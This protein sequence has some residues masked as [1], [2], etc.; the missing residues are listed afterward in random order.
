MFGFLFRT[1]VFQL[2]IQSDWMTIFVLSSLFVLSIF[3]IWIVICKILNIRKQKR[4]MY[5]LLQEIKQ[6]K[7]FNELLTVSKKFKECAGGRLLVNGLKELKKLSEQK[8]GKLSLQEIEYLQLML[9]QILDT[10][11]IEEERYLPVLGTSAAVSPLIGL[12]G[13]IWGLVD[14]FVSISQEKSADISVVAPGIA[15]ALT[16]T[17]AGLIVAIPAL[18]FFHYFSNELR[19]LEQQ[20]ISIS[21]RFLNII[22]QS[23]VQ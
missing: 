15:K 22:K 11:L 12:F 7:S 9:D 19:K 16:T 17:L 23:F 1:P 8:E 20:L 13:T 5:F 18:I 10:V 4:A 14:A 2:I 6:I 3:C 21:D